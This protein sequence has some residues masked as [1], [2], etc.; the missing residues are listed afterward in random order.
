MRAPGGTYAAVV[1]SFSHEIILVQT[2]Q[3]VG[4]HWVWS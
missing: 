1:L 3:V 2:R 4:K